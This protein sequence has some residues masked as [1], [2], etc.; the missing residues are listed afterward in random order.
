MGKHL[1]R[2]GMIGG[3]KR[4]KIP[5]ELLLDQ[6]PGRPHKW[7]LWIPILLAAVAG[8]M[9]AI[10]ARAELPEAE[11]GDL[12]FKTNGSYVQ[13]TH[14][15][16]DVT[17]D[18][19]G[20]IARTTLRQRFENQT[21]E[22]Q[23]AVYVFP[24][25]ETAAVNHMEM[26]IG[27]RRIVSRIKEKEEARRI[28][29]QAKASGKKAALTEQQRPNLFSQAVANIAPHETIEVE[30][31]FIDRVGYASG[32][33]D[34]RLPL[35]LTPRYIPGTAREADSTDV[36]IGQFGWTQPTD[37]VLDAANITPPM[38]PAGTATNLATI[39]F[40]INAGIELRD[41]DSA[42]HNIRTIKH[43]QRYD[44]TLRKGAVAMD[45]DFVLTWQPVVGA[46]PHAA[47]FTERVDGKD[48][49]LLMVLPPQLETTTSLPRD[50]IFIVDTS[51]SMQGTSIVQAR[52]GLADALSRLRPEDRFN[53]IRFSNNYSYAFPTLVHADNYYV[54]QARQW[55]TTLTAGGG[56]EM[57]GPLAAALDT[58]E[59]E[60]Y[61]KHIVFITDGAVGNEAA[62]LKTINDKLGNSRLF[63]IGI[64]SAPNSYF[65]RKSSQFG[66]GTFTHIGKTE[67]VAK[68]MA[69]LYEKIEH[70]VATGIRL[71]L[72]G[73]ANTETFPKA[74]PA[75][76]LSEPLVLAIR[77][78]QLGGDARIEGVNQQGYW[79]RSIPITAPT[80]TS[81]IATLWARAKIESLEDEKITGADPA[82]VRESVLALAL[83]HHLVSPYTSLVAV[84][85][86]ISRLPEDKLNAG[87]V[88][89]TTARGQTASPVMYPKTATPAGA[90]AL[91]GAMLALLALC[92]RPATR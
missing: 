30:L 65:M 78:D 54:S 19:T 55:V 37:Q 72:P 44:V 39:T 31:R 8:A 14:L 75:L 27:D 16:T 3:F 48:Y 91:L 46:Q 29:N 56:T 10:D 22:W 41:I 81:G 71:H 86:L 66:R 79:E 12:L 43:A 85:E 77:G 13:A 34:Y 67:E 17:V 7:W 49:A 69:A 9:F 59:D 45:R 70:P 51:G 18:V 15:N 89:S 35:T 87:P 61:L 4:R 82:K 58:P 57:A 80:E 47:L 2:H 20:I 23:E 84:E 76:Y 25:P 26:R 42:Y 92:L 11:A 24:L 90:L 40:H 60:R 88:P 62:L 52:Q 33:F 50:M 74:I 36:S 32:S 68:K 6:P 83:T 53:I 5:K 64:G 38:L 73:S 63:T 28:Y 1:Y 21:D